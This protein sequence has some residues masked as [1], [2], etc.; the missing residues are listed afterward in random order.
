MADD[1][2]G[3]WVPGEATSAYRAARA[4]LAELQVTA[5]QCVLGN[6]EAARVALVA[7]DRGLLI[8]ER[9]DLDVPGRNPTIG[10]ALRVAVLLVA[11]RLRDAVLGVERLACSQP[12]P[13]RRRVEF[14]GIL[15]VLLT[16][17]IAWPA[18]PAT[19]P[20]ATTPMQAAVAA[21][22]ATRSTRRAL[23]PND[24]EALRRHARHHVSEAG[25]SKSGGI[26]KREGKISW[27]FADEPSRPNPNMHQA[28]TG[29]RRGWRS[30]APAQAPWRRSDRVSRASS[31]PTRRPQSRR[32]SFMSTATDSEL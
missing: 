14:S 3:A 27:T 31:N 5:D 10:L 19:T 2:S 23:A 12:L 7:S 26:K 32:A 1:S 18:P 20:P 6:A 17:A 8:A 25:A 28:T 9:L 16:A 24:F 30:T 22:T 15:A 29:P 4:G 11:G 13:S 21:P